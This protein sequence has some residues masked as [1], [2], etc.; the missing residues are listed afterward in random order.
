M[1]ALI[2]Y[3]SILVLLATFAGCRYSNCVILRELS[4]CR[5]TVDTEQ[6]AEGTDQGKTLEDVASGNTAKLQ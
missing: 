3:L 2:R 1:T 5:V 4:D 6:L